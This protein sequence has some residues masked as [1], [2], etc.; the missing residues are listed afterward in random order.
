M[1]WNEVYIY[2]SL[3]KTNAKV[4]LYSCKVLL[5]NKVAE[6]HVRQPFI[7]YLKKACFMLALYPLLDEDA[8][9]SA[10]TFIIFDLLAHTNL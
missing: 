4:H 1:P 5:C 7:C 10:K 3:G 6:K 2:K 9:R 8:F